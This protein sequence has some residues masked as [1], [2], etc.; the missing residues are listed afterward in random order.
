MSRSSSSTTR[1]ARTSAT[2][3]RRPQAALAAIKERLGHEPDLD[4]R[5]I[6]AGAAATR[7]RR[8]RHEAV[9]GARPGDV[10]CPAPAPRR[11]RHDHR[12][13]GA[14]RA[15]RRRQGLAAGG[16]RP[17][18]RLAVGAAERGRPPARRLAGAELWH[19][20]QAVAAEDPGRGPAR[21]RR[22]K[23][24]RGHRRGARDLAQGR[25]RR[26]GADGAGRPG[27]HLAGADRSWRPQCAGARSRARPARADPRQQPRRRRRQRR[28]RPLAGAAGVGRTPCRRAGVAQPAQIRPVGRSRPFHDPAPAGKAGR[29]ADSRIVADRLSDPRAV[30]HQA[31]RFRPDHLRPLQ[32]ARGH[33]RGLSRKRRALRA[34]RRRL[35]RSG[36]SEFWHADEPVALAARGDLAGRAD[37]GGVRGGVQAASDRSRPP[38]SGDRGPARRRAARR[39]AQLGAVVPPG[40]RPGASWRHRDDR[41]PRRP[42]VGARPRRQGPGGAAAVRRDVVLGARFRGRRAAGRAAAPAGLLVDEGARS[43]RKRPARHGRRRSSGGDPPVARTRRPAGHGD[44]TRRVE[45]EP[46][47][48]P[49]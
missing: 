39:R 4:L 42:A 11:D 35:A 26:A 12:R 27:R 25:R 21:K 24:R 37:R 2:A 3:G 36:G 9:R 47:A 23:G 7:R 17:A 34:E 45:P 5:V 10:G 22:R 32:P 28:A 44:R 40:R 8:R 31:R 15:G 33:P 43:R 13:R 30:R 46:E 48:D 1:R 38:R 18:A 16:S 20:R 14:R 29:H 41:R 6:R 19:C 49:G